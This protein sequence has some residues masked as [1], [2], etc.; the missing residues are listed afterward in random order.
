AVGLILAGRLKE[1][2]V[3]YIL[4]VYYGIDNSFW[5]LVPHVVQWLMIFCYHVVVVG[6]L[7]YSDSSYSVPCNYWDAVSWILWLPCKALP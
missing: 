1:L 6:I 3:V 5:D 2:K 7:Q 4:T